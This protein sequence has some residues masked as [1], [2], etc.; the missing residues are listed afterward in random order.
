[1]QAAWLVVGCPDS[2]LLLLPLLLLC[3]LGGQLRNSRSI[4]IAAERRQR[5]LRRS[6]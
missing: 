6:V 4:L 1:M 5:Q 2:H 3:D